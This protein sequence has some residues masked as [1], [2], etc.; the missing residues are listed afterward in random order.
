LI[1]FWIHINVP[2]GTTLICNGTEP[3][4]NQ[5]IDIHVGWNLVGYPSL[6]NR[7][8]D[9]ALNNTVFGSDVDSIWTYDSTKQEWMELKNPTDYFE[10]GQGYW[11]HSKVD[12]TWNI[13][14]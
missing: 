11:I 7:Q 13:P 5:N 6:K 14:L 9:V 10:V 8:R 3:T 12:K 4:V 2:G 1:S